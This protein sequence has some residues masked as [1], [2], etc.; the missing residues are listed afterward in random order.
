MKDIVYKNVKEG[1]YKI[2]EYGNI[3]SNYKKGYLSPAKDKDGYLKIKLSGGSRNQ[4]CYV[5]IATLVA[6]HFI[7]RPP[8]E[9][10]DPTINHIDGNILNNHFSNLEWIERGIN[11]S[12]RK[13]KGSGICNHEAK[14]N[15]R[16]VKEICEL[17]CKTTLTIQEIGNKYGVEK[18]TISNILRRKTWK[19][20]TNNYDFSHRKLIRNEKGQFEIVL[21]NN[22]GKIR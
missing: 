6:W 17:L 4:K 18:S 14:L 16:E 9:L 19:E 11:S 10:N 22:E 21:L 7:G 1:L 2:D 12:I 15:E 13:N 8:E 20:I 5:R 3:W